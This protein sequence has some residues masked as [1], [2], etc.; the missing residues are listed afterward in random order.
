MGADYGSQSCHLEYGP[1]SVIN[2]KK[3]RKKTKST[4]RKKFF[5]VATMS[6][7]K[8]RKKTTSTGRKRF[9]CSNNVWA[10][11]EKEN[12]KHR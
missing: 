12:N 9:P 10:E 4:G 5:P 2:R 8:Q 3:K 1:F 6:G 7:Q 11:E